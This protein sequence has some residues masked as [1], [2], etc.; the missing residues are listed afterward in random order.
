MVKKGLCSSRDLVERLSGEFLHFLQRHINVV[1]GEFVSDCLPFIGYI[2][3][4]QPNLSITEF[5]IEADL[6]LECFDKL[7][8]LLA[9]PWQV[10]LGIVSNWY[11]FEG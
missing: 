11:N 6:L 4:V 2:G 1:L 8:C 7:T 10:R 5:F 9:V 3:I